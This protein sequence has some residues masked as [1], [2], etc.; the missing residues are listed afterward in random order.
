M[1]QNVNLQAKQ[2]K[3]IWAF[4]RNV[5]D[6]YHLS[7]IN[8][9]DMSI[10]QKCQSSMFMLFYLDPLQNQAIVTSRC[11]HYIFFR[12][13]PT[14]KK[15]EGKEKG[16]WPLDEKW[17]HKPVFVLYPVPPFPFLLFS[18]QVGHSRLSVL[19]FPLEKKYSACIVMSWIAWFCRESK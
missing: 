3:L 19:P 2:L 11:M 10:L 4:Y 14:W 13:C 15:K 16:K 17:T 5:R 18:S 12:E 1:I 6:L 8:G 9:T 7:E